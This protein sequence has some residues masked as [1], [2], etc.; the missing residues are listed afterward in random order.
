MKAPYPQRAT[1]SSA[2]MTSTFYIRTGK[3][4]MD[5]V[6]ASV[7]L[8]V[9]S[10]LLLLVALAVRLSSPGPAL[11]RQVRTGRFEKPFSIWKFRTMRP[12][13]SGPLLTAA[14]DSRITPLGKYLRKTKLDEFPQLFNVFR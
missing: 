7:G 10:P 9:L 5:L 2:V 6:V 8:L 4:L 13:S 12:S 3:R 1:T 11:F 14:G